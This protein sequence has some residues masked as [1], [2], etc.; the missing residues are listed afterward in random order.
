MLVR[1][2]DVLARGECTDEH[3]ERAARH[4]EVRDERVNH[5]KLAA[6]QQVQAGGIAIARRDG[7]SPAVCRRVP[8]AFQAAHA[9]GAHGNHATAVCVRAVDGVHRFLRHRVKFGMHL[10]RQRVFLVHDAERV[11]AH[12]KLNGFPIDTLG[13]NA[14]DKLGREMQ[15]RGGR[16][17][18]AFA[19]RVHGLVQLLV[20]GVVLDVGRQRSVAHGMKR[21]VKRGVRGGQT[22]HALAA[23]SAFCPIDD[24]GRQRHVAVS[25]GEVNHRAAARLQALARAHEHLPNCLLILAGLRCAGDVRNVSVLR[26][27]FTHELA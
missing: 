18:R 14:L 2:H 16:G 25:V 13:P 4:V 11:K 21:L 7:A 27:F 3:H 15:A 19:A 26:R 8:R 22:R 24:L 6:R 5:V 1:V 23:L 9:G 12:L 20:A 17:G 10:V